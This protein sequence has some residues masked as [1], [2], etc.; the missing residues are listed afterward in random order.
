MADKTWPAEW[1]NKA[2]QISIYTEMLK[3]IHTAGDALTEARCAVLEALSKAPKRGEQDDLASL[4]Q[5]IIAVEK[6]AGAREGE[7]SQRL[8]TFQRLASQQGAR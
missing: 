2:E 3:R 5:Q 8:Q 1:E 4:L 6:V 7:I